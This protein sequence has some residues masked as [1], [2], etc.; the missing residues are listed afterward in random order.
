VF[1]VPTGD[2]LLKGTYRFPHALTSLS[3]KYVS[4]FYL[5]L[6]W[7]KQSSVLVPGVPAFGHVG[8]DFNRWAYE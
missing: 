2:V 8:V 7:D 5:M 4:I 6:V 3:I 1:L